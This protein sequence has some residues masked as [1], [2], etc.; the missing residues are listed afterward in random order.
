MRWIECVS[1]AIDYIETNITGELTMA[2]VAR[3]AMISPFY[4]QKGFAMLCGFTVSEYIRCRR[5]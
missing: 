2:S 3:K 4:F 1:E 5:L